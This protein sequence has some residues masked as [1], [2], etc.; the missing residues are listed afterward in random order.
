[1]DGILAP[2][3]INIEI[4]KN[5]SQN[6][7]IEANDER[8]Y[9]PA[10][11]TIPEDSLQN[12]VMHTSITEK[13]FIQKLW[14][15]IPAE[16]AKDTINAI[17]CVAVFIGSKMFYFSR[18]DIALFSG[19]K[20]YEYMLLQLPVR[21]SKSLFKDWLN[22]Y[23]D[24]NFIVKGIEDF[25]F[26]PIRFIVTWFFILFLIVI[27]KNELTEYY[28]TLD[29]RKKKYVEIILFLFIVLFGFILRIN[30]YVRYSAWYDELYSASQAGN[31]SLPFM[32]AFTDP[33]NP[34]FYFIVLRFWFIIFG[35][36]EQSG[37]F[38]SV[39]IGTLAIPLIYFTVRCFS[40]KKPAFWAALF[41]ASSAYLI[42]YSQEMRAYTLEIVLALFL[43]FV[44]LRLL[45]T[46]NA[47]CMVLY[48]FLAILVVNT[49][50]YGAL[51]I[52]ANFIFFIIHAFHNKIYKWKKAILF[53]VSNVIIALS[54]L[55]YFLYTA[56]NKALLD[57]AFNTQ[58]AELSLEFFI[59]LFSIIL[60]LIGYYFW[61]MY[62]CKKGDSK[63]YILCD[64]SIVA[65]C[66]IFIQAF[67][68]SVFRPI[69]S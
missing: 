51:L 28:T 69:I 61:R 42:G 18:S 40:G 57:Q 54:L 29:K 37:R 17:E 60:F 63:K 11:T 9:F 46:Q 39:L 21:Y 44:F 15:R 56:L 10:P 2:I 6:I 26:F 1:M 16:K 7:S 68:F 36:S 67:V 13:E 49:H 43:M 41:M 4:N 64:Y 38:L 62:F 47:I 3:N 24:F 65:S 22:W 30:G 20:N 27:F 34:P 66:L 53:F 8:I 14:L 32:A 35:W 55:P 50:Y 48:T 25:I 33:G 59:A 31:P 5:A 45:K 58:I 23:G 19:T 52:S 12:I